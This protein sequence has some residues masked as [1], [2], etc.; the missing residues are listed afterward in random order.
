LANEPKRFVEM[1]GGHNDGIELSDEL[2]REAMEDF[3]GPLL[4]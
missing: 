2:R 3:V 4:E 1:R